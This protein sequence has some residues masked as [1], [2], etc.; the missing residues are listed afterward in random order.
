MRYE[1]LEL[2]LHWHKWV[3]LKTVSR[4]YHLLFRHLFLS[5]Y[6]TPPLFPPFLIIAFLSVN[7]WM[8]KILS[9]IVLSAIFGVV[10]AVDPIHLPLRYTQQTTKSIH[11]RALSNSVQLYNAVMQGAYAIDLS[12]GTPGT[13]M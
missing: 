11:R 3:R 8:A 2:L 10:S 9:A 6:L 7:F 12:I 1:F 4:R 13:R 5:S